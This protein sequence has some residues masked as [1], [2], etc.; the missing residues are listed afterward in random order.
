MWTERGCGVFLGQIGLDG[1]FQV[2]AGDGPDGVE[3]G[4]QVRQ[5]I[6]GI[7]RTSSIVCPNPVRHRVHVE[8]G[9]PSRRPAT[10][11]EPAATGSLQP[12]STRAMCQTNQAI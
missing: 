2:V 7:A 1:L 3:V 8:A 10:P 6:S 4:H 9:L 12:S 11:W 5:G